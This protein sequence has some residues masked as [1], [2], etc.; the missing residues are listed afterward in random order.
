MALYVH[1][2][3]HQVSENEHTDSD[4]NIYNN[5][6]YLCTAKSTELKLKD[7]IPGFEYIIKTGHH[8]WL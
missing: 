3:E 7:N 2:L 1:L 8:G 6:D 4:S 5:L